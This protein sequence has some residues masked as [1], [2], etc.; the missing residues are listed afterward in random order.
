MGSAAPVSARRRHL[1]VALG[2][3]IVLHNAEEGLAF[4]R[5]G[6]PVAALLRRWGVP[7]E[8][9]P[10]EAMRAGLIAATLVPLLLIGIAT[11]GART[12]WKDAI[13]AGVAAVFLLNVFVPHVPAAV[14][15]GGY[16]P[17]IVTALLL[18]LPI[19]TLMI[20]EVA[21]GG[22]LRPSALRVALLAGAFA[23]PLTL[24]ILLALR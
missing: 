15:L 4:A 5:F 9:L 17:G 14:A 18:N 11:L 21:R 23:L 12:E 20:R 2:A 24:A 22:I 6:E 19:C 16:A 8:P 13:L 3:A 7:I 1:A 10:W